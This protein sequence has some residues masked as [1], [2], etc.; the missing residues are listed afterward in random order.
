MLTD[1]IF[2]L[3]AIILL[4]DSG[5]GNRENQVLPPFNRKRIDLQ[6]FFDLLMYQ[7]FFKLL[8]FK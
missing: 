5:F 3:I 1:N 8:N 7:I 4:P 2:T 6:I